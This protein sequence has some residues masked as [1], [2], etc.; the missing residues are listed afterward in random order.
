MVAQGAVPLCSHLPQ[1]RCTTF[2]RQ[3]VRLQQLFC[4]TSSPWNNLV[5]RRSRYGIRHLNYIVREHILAPP[6]FCTMPRLVRGLVLCLDQCR[7]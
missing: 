1:A 5:L 2:V 4:T 7:T 3:H 6:L